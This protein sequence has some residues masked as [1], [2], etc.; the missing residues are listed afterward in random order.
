VVLVL[1]VRV[2]LVLVLVVRVVLVFGRL[3]RRLGRLVSAV[4]VRVVL[5][6]ALIVVV[7]A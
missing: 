2:V 1:V 7:A 4:V 6:G 3:S 5:L